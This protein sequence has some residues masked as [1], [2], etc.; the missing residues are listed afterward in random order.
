MRQRTAMIAQFRTLFFLA[1]LLLPLA[2]PAIAHAQTVAPGQVAQ[3]APAAER[4]GEANLVLPDLGTQTFQGVNGRTLLMGGLVVCVLGLVFGMVIFMRLK[5]MPVH[6]SL[7]EV[8]EL[9]YETMSLIH[10]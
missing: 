7:L 5:H 1:A 9:I 10:I 2:L 8:S 3:P 6:R 4:A